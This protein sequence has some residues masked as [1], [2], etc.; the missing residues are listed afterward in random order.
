MTPRQQKFAEYYAQ[1]GNTVQAAIKAGYAESYANSRAHE[2]L[3]NVG[4]A[5]YL[6]AIGAKETESRI[7]SA[8]KRQEILSDLATDESN[9]PKDRIKAIDTLNKMTGEYTMRVDA[10]VQPSQKLA[11]VMAQLGGRGLTDED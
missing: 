6:R 7:L 2:L 3:E 11:D 10:S 1:C 5:S 4:V 9:E 8:T